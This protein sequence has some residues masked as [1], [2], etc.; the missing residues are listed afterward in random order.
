MKTHYFFIIVILVVS[1][2]SV[3]ASLVPPPIIGGMVDV[4]GIPTAGLIIA[5]ENLDTGEFREQTTSYDTPGGTIGGYAVCMSL[6]TGDVLRI[7]CNY[8]ESIYSNTTIVD[9]E[10]RIQWLNLS[11]DTGNPPPDTDEDGIPDY[12]DNCPNTYNPDQED[13]DDDGIGDVCDEPDDPSDDPSDDPPD[14]PPGD[15]DD[16]GDDD[17]D[18]DEQDDQ[19]DDDDDQ[20]EDEEQ[21]TVNHTL[22][23]QIFDNKT[24]QPISNATVTIYDNQS[25]QITENKT[26]TDGNVTFLLSEG[27]YSVAVTKDDYDT[28]GKTITLLESMQTTLS[29]DENVTQPENNTGDELPQNQNAQTPFVGVGSIFV[30]IGMVFLFYRRKRTKNTK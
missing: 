9:L 15:D 1:P 24:K 23:L 26:D 13:S 3:G 10:L 19:Q 27:N 16:Q 14:D 6:H 11:I 7:T 4:D 25:N 21:E 20:D 17:D 18:D 22:A 28:T 30:V 8:D 2:F 29:L 5:V 12:Y